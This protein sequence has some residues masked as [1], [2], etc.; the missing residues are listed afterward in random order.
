MIDFKTTEVD[1]RLRIVGMGAPG[2]AKLGEIVTVTKALDDRVF[3]K[4]AKGVEV[5]F[6]LT[7]GAS[8]L[9]NECQ[10]PDPNQ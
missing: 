6:V 1:D 5:Y 9:E 3:V 7:C 10:A 2:F 4:N 8:R